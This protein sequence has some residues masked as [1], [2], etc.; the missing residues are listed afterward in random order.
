LKIS[1]FLVLRYSFEDST[2]PDLD[3]DDGDD[4]SSTLSTPDRLF[5]G[6]DLGNGSL[7]RVK[8]LVDRFLIRG[9]NTP[10]NWLLDLRNYGL[11]IARTSTSSG[12]IDWDGETI[13]Y[14][15]ISFSISN[16]RSFLHGLTSSTRDILF[17][18]I[19]F[20]NSTF[21]SDTPLRPIPDIPW[22]GIFDNPIDST[23]FSNFLSDSRTDLGL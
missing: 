15:S 11:K 22:E 19:L 23:P 3:D 12:Y 17:R 13:L 9:S 1:R 18:E 7:D 14:G 6:L 4:D 21:T 20:E 5:S 10:M 16:F 2:T 8:V